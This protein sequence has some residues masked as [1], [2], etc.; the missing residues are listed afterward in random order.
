MYTLQLSLADIFD[1]GMARY[2]LKKVILPARSLGG[3]AH[4]LLRWITFSPA[5][6]LL[7]QFISPAGSSD[8]IAEG[9]N[10]QR[11]TPT[12]TEMMPVSS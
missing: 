6:F 11:S 1:T 7:S 3:S 8:I 9:L 2:G 12:K 5:S 10:Y 4:G